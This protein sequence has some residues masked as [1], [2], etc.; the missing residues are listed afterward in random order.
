MNRARGQISN[1]EDQAEGAVPRHKE[2]K[3]QR[4][5]EGTRKMLWENFSL[6]PMR[7]GWGDGMPQRA[8]LKRKS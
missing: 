7:T 4:K 3:A 8:N 2:V 1:V 5:T 6:C